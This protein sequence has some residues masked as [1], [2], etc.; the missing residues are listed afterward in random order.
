[1]RKKDTS[2]HRRITDGLGEYAK[3][4]IYSVTI[5]LY[6]QHVICAGFIAVLCKNRRTSNNIVK[7]VIIMLKVTIIKYNL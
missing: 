5:S 7:Y 4:E 1:M 3:H 6:H 2:V